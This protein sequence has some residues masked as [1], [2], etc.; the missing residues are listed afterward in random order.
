MIYFKVTGLSGHKTH[1]GF[2]FGSNTL[3][4]VSS[5]RSVFVINQVICNI[6]N[7][8]RMR[9]RYRKGVYTFKTLATIIGIFINDLKIKKSLTNN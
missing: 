4:R 5:I 1:P 3:S 7:L 6:L 8:L 9:I 2:C